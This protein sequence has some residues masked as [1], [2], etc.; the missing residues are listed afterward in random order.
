MI[1]SALRP[2]PYAATTHVARRC[3]HG[4]GHGHGLFI[5]ATYHEG[6]SRAG[7]WWY[8]SNY[9]AYP[10]LKKRCVDSCLVMI[11][12]L[13]PWCTFS[14]GP[15]L[16]QI[17]PPRI[18]RIERIERTHTQTLT[19]SVPTRFYSILRVYICIYIYTYICTCVRPNQCSM[20]V[21][22]YVHVW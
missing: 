11:V 5:L 17:D 21:Y 14:E 20:C 13:W 12:R 9:W 15:R 4:H 18:E 19:K 2:S 3:C 7:S 6:C 10:V 16:R 22:M 1:A 8:N